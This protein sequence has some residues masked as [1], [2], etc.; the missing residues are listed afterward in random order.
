[1][2]H[3]LRTLTRVASVLAAAGLTLGTTVLGAPSASAGPR[4]QPCI[5]PDTGTNLQHYFDVTTALV[6]PFGACGQI[7]AGSA[8]STP[9]AFYNARTWEQIPAGYQP[10]TDSPSAELAAHL[11]TVRLIVDEGTHHSFTVER[12]GPQLQW[13]TADWQELYTS[14]PDWVLADVGTHFA[15]RPLSVGTHTVRGEFYLDDTVCDGTSAD[16]NASCIPPGWF[17][18][19]ET[20]TFTV[21]PHS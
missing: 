7:V 2:N 19:P 13:A 6:V 1:M 14:D 5:W 3:S 12:S 18:Y 17:D 9:I 15:L 8:W 16:P 11:T 20:R 10:D 4:V 21:V